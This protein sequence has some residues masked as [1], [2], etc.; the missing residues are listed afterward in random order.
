[1][2]LQ[3]QLQ[4]L[5][6]GACE[7]TF[8]ATEHQALEVSRQLGA[9][10]LQRTH[11]L[12]WWRKR[13]ERSGLLGWREARETN[14]GAGERERRAARAHDRMGRG[15]VGVQEGYKMT[16]VTHTHT[17]VKKKVIIVAVTFRGFVIFSPSTQTLPLDN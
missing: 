17:V 14:G 10:D 8:V 16:F 15:D 6:T 5:V 4:G 12:L 13:R 1:M 9:A 2:L 3:V 11:A 7:G